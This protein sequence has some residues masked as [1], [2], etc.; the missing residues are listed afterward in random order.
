MRI[1]PSDEEPR[2]RAGERRHLTVMFCDLVGSS[3]LVGQLDP[4]DWNDIVS[5]YHETCEAVVRRFDAHVAEKLGDGL[6]AYFGWPAAHE[7]DAYR[8]IRTGLRVIDAMQALNARLEQ[9]QG[10]RLQVRIGIDTGTVVVGRMGEGQKEERATGNALIV[11]SRLQ[12]LAKPDTVVISGT[13]SNLVHGYFTQEDLGLQH[14][15]NIA[16]PVHAYRVVG[17]SGVDQRL[18]AVGNRALT[19]L[20]GR[21]SELKVLLNLWDRAAAGQ[22]QIVFIEGEPGIGKSRLVKVLRQ[23]IANCIEFRC[24]AYD[25]HSA[26]FPVVR[27]LE[28]LLGFEQLEDAGEKLERLEHKL[29]GLGFSLPHVVPL[30]ASQFSLPLPDRYPSPNLP[31]AKK[32][33]ET[34]NVLVEW[35]LKEAEQ[36]PLMAVW[37]DLHWADP[38]TIE[39]LGLVIERVAKTVTPLLVL[40][41]FRSDEFQ[42]PWTAVAS[43]TEVVLGRLERPEVEE[44][45]RRIT[46]DRSLPHEVVDQIF[47]RTDG[48]PLFVEELLQTVLDSGSVRTEGD[49]FVIA[50]P[51]SPIAIPE[52]LEDLLMSRLDRLGAA[53]MI[54]QRGA[55]LGRTFS[56]DLLRAV[57]E[58]DARDAHQSEDQS[59]EAWRSAERCLTRLVEAGVLRQG[60]TAQTTY[61]FRHALIQ[62]A[63]DQSLLNRNRQAYHLQTARVLETEFAQVV[64]TQPEVVARH[65]T[66]AVQLDRVMPHERP[67]VHR[68]LDCWQ[69][70]GEHARHRSANK[71]A[72]HHFA[73][74]LRTLEALPESDERDRRELALRIASITPIIAVEG[75]V[76]DAI[77]RTA[78]RALV[79]C[80][81]LG[82][83]DRLFPVLYVLWVNRLVGAK[84]ADALRLS[85]EFSQEANSQQDPGP[86]L[87]S[88][89]LRG[90]SLYM[91]GELSFAEEQLRRSLDLYDPQRHSELKNQGYG[92][93][94][95]C[96][97]EAF[98][99]QVRWLRGYPDDS[100]KWSRRSLEHGGESRHSN[101]WGY[102]LCWGGATWDLFR[103]D[104]ASAEQRASELMA[105]SVRERLPVWLAYA[106][107]FHGWTLV[108]TDRAEDGIAEMKTGLIH[109]EDASSTTAASD[110]LHMGFMK[111]FLLSLLAEGYGKLGRAEEGLAQL[112]AALAFANARGEGFWKA[113]V[114]RLKGELLLLTGRGRSD[115]KAQEAEACFQK[116]RDIASAQGAKALELRAVMSLSRLWCREK[117]FEAREILREAYDAFTEGFDSVDLLEAHRLLNELPGT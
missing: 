63:A 29:Q 35:L 19:P 44:M 110:S 21:E 99:S 83:V 4:E 97:C 36:E 59:T 92:Q 101:T 107:V 115:G 49:H 37:E 38:S 58:T 52:R 8:A 87:M 50:R 113:E 25:S 1:L 79:L 13:T 57:L 85:E 80:R 88:H 77:A 43:A 62:K 96:A 90:F 3:R 18:E 10:V 81:R 112:D 23:S 109:F 76:A 17:E 40:M 93:D 64:D 51:S 74:G 33:Q 82:D 32:R 91:I 12:G 46:N 31:A 30:F 22:G 16:N 94:P 27:R 95:R 47:E 71:E 108:Q 105:F 116:A 9:D 55:I 7:D 2:P 114:L 15:T 98:M 11:A 26:L 20:I 61:E 45:I 56:Q 60:G 89:R 67:T 69:K 106:S 102:V 39:L 104:F 41:T 5:A 53:K 65:Y 111:S 54:A 75:Y 100:A 73:E 117:P 72:I 24:S 66:Q 28:R 14:L 6:I 68:A 48:L 42:S 86:R 78:E 70:A 34:L 84:Y 103:R